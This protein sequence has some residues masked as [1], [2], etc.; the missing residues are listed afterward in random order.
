MSYTILTRSNLSGPRK[1][2]KIGIVE[3]GW[4]LRKRRR[5]GRLLQRQKQHERWL[6]KHREE[7]NEWL[8]DWRKRLDAERARFAEK[9][10]VIKELR[11]AERVR[12]RERAAQE[13]VAEERGDKTRKWP[14]WTQED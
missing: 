6:Q 9:E 8:D 10:R 2:L 3:R 14:R 4:T 12:K 13:N 5:Q 7:Q 11:E 1:R